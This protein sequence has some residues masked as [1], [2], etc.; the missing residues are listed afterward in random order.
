LPRRPQPPGLLRRPLRP[1]RAPALGVDLGA[2]AAPPSPAAASATRAL[3]AA[4]TTPLLPTAAAA[5][6]GP[7]HLHRDSSG[8]WAVALPAEPLD[9]VHSY[10]ARPVGVHSATRPAA[11]AGHA[12]PAST[13]LDAAGPARLVSGPAR[14]VGLA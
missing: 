13:S 7:L 6:W 2:P 3:A 10:V 8:T 1:S 9:R 4:L 5:A 14:P 12:G 11:A